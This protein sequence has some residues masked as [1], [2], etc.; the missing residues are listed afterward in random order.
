METLNKLRALNDEILASIEDD[1]IQ[2]EIEQSDMFSEWIQQCLCHLEQLILSKPPP[3]PG[4]MTAAASHLV[5]LLQILT[6]QVSQILHQY[7]STTP[8]IMAAK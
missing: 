2:E 8:E 7:Q 5:S 3:P 6:Q 1:A 4:H